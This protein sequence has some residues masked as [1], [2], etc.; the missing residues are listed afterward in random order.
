MSFED[1]AGLNSPVD[2]VPDETPDVPY[3]ADAWS[4]AGASSGIQDTTAVDLV[5]AVA[6]KRHYLKA[7][8]FVNSDASVDTEVLIQSASTTIWRGF[9][10]AAGVGPVV[11]NFPVPLR[12]EVGEALRVKAGT[13]SAQLIVSAQG[14]TK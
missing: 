4:Y 5:A 12:T 14:Y 3:G 2:D 9:A 11:I 10:K 6:A 13:T 1:L 7:L 8:Q